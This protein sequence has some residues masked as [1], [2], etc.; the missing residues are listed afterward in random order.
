MSKNCV[1][2]DAFGVKNGV[3]SE[4]MSSALAVQLKNLD[5]G[6]SPAMGL[7][8]VMLTAKFRS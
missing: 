7:G 4:N 1:V 5:A 2:L 8:P 6:P 3:G